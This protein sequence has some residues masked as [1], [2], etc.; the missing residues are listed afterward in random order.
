M[1]SLLSSHGYSPA[2]TS[3][4]LAVAGVGGMLGS[5]VMASLV[6]TF[7]S[8]IALIIVTVTAAAT[9]LVLTQM[10]LIPSRSAIPLLVALSIVS[11]SLNALTG[12]IYAL[13]A[14]V[15]PPNVK[16]TGLGT[17]GAVGRIGAIA[18]SYAA[19]AMLSI[20]SQAFF[21]FIGA[22]AVLSLLSLM[23]VKRHIP[24][25]RAFVRGA[26]AVR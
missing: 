24:S 19:V 23:I 15:Y 26:A 10:P 8:R 25:D 5:V 12:C 1:P 20:G 22:S 4:A 18:S 6:E 2:I 3:L 13:A 17:A 14:F 7:G 9:A 16:G 21:G 11:L